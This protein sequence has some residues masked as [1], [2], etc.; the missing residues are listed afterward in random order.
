MLF[1]Q[2]P[3]T[4][5]EVINRVINDWVGDDEPVM[6]EAY[7]ESEAESLLGSELE[8]ELDADI[9]EIEFVNFMDGWHSHER[10]INRIILEVAK[11]PNV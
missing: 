6:T 1:E 5:Q 11:E 8:P 10:M 2:L 3:L 9:I 7:R 4:Y